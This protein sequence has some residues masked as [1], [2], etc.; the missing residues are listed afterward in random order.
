[1]MNRY[2]FLIQLNKEKYQKNHQLT[3]QLSLHMSFQESIRGKSFNS[4]RPI[5]ID[6]VYQVYNLLCNKLS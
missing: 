5:S 4:Y 3:A 6:Y 2:P 1:M